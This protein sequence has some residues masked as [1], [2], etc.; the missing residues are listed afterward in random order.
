MHSICAGLRLSRVNDIQL[1]TISKVFAPTIRP[2]YRSRNIAIEPNAAISLTHRDFSLISGAPTHC[3][4]RQQ[5][6]RKMQKSRLSSRIWGACV[7]RRCPTDYEKPDI[8]LKI[9]PQPAVYE[10]R[11]NCPPPPHPNPPA[12]PFW[13]GVRQFAI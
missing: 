8:F 3:P 13:G 10:S 2:Y 12:A 5:R 7:L 9:T 6:R 1:F 4:R 11:R